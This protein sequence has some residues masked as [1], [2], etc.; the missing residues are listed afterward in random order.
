MPDQNIY[1]GAG[2]T[3]EYVSEF[4]GEKK[5]NIFTNSLYLLEN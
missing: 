3:I 5:L 2:T 4:I 1:L